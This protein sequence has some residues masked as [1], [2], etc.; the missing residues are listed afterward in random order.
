MSEW[1]RL[2]HPAD[3]SLINPPIKRT[4]KN[5]TV[6][7]TVDYFQNKRPHLVFG[8]WRDYFR[9]EAPTAPRTLNGTA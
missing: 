1:V 6:L 2:T 9:L 4:K 7:I 5:K 8:A 3:V